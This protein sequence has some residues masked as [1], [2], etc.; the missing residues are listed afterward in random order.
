M[1][2]LRSVGW[3]R[4]LTVVSVGTLCLLVAGAGAIAVWARLNNTWEHFF[5][6]EETFAT[7]TPIVVV[8]GAVALVASIGAVLR[9]G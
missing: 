9:T 8:V 6:M 5:L 2:E 1:R 3:Y 7:L 4:L